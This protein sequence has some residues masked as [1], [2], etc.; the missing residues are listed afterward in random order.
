MESNKRV[1]ENKP[2]TRSVDS[3]QKIY[4]VIIGLA[5]AR[6]TQEVVQGTNWNEILPR[7]QA[8]AP[9][10]L[11][12]FFLIVPFYHGMNRHLDYSYLERVP[13]HSKI[14]L[15]MDFIFFSLEAALFFLFADTIILGKESFI[16]IALILGL[17][18][19]WGTF[20]TLLNY[21]KESGKQNPFAWVKINIVTLIFGFFIYVYGDNPVIDVRW[22]LA[23]LLV[24]RTIIDYY[25]MMDFY[26]PEEPQAP[27][28]T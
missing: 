22:C 27:T 23:V 18:I 26:F 10:L 24:G 1:T 20:A 8:T 21:H 25:M 11:S 12:F 13:Q 14:G 2:L 3:L 28:G 17:D 9:A 6:T 7:I 19:L 5:I 15:I 4:A 16:V